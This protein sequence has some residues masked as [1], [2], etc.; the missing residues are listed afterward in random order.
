MDTDPRWLVLNGLRG[1]GGNRAAVV[2]AVA[3]P[4]WREPADAA[5]DPGWDD[6]LARPASSSSYAQNPGSVP[7]SAPRRYAVSRTGKTAT[8]HG[9]EPHQTPNASVQRLRYEPRRPPLILLSSKASNN[10]AVTASTSA[11]TPQDPIYGCSTSCR[12]SGRRSR[13]FADP[14]RPPGPVR[15]RS[16]VGHGWSVLTRLGLY[17]SGPHP[18]H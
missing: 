3:R 9:R 12:R 4:T 15:I 1:V 6:P 10:A 7:A 5:A 17:W 8:R 16:A 11:D 14:R 13:G 18:Q 2:L